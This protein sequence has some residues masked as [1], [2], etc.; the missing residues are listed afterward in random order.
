MLRGLALTKSCV[1]LRRNI[2][3]ISRAARKPRALSTDGYSSGLDGSV[4]QIE[5]DLANK[6][7][8]ELRCRSLDQAPA[9]A[10]HIA[11]GSLFVVTSR[12]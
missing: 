4:A 5:I 6:R 2:Y 11:V 10:Q 3:S 1:L 8:R 12:P 9:R 7:R